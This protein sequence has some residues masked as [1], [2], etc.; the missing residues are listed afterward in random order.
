VALNKPYNETCDVYSFCILLWQI[1]KAETPFDGYT[2]KMLTKKVTVEG[3]RPKPDDKA[4][5]TELC[6]MLR[7]GWH[8]DIAQRPG[9]ETISDTLRDI[10]NKYSD[11][12]INEIMDASRK[13]ELSLRRGSGNS[14]NLDSLRVAVPT[15]TAT[16]KNENLDGSSG[17]HFDI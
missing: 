4:W 16:G 6:N 11:E 7:L 10:V 13:S 14:I 1:L 12:E 15:A 9:M 5:P 2:M 8:A 17:S 3:V